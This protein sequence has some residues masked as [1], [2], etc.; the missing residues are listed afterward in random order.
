MINLLEMHVNGDVISGK[1]RSYMQAVDAYG[2][3]MTHPRVIR[4][5]GL[6]KCVH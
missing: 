4:L 2:W 1:Y 6:G 3:R 5:D